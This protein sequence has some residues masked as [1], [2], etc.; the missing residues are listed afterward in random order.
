MDTFLLHKGQRYE[1]VVNGYTYVSF[2]SNKDDFRA[3][4][5]SVLFEWRCY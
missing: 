4:R 5:F 1:V 2:Q 3:L